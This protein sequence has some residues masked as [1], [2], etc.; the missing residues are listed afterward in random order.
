MSRENPTD[1][2][3]Y[4]VEDGVVTLTLNRPHR[5]NAWLA[6]FGEVYMDRLDQ[7]ALD[8]EV[9]AIVITGAGKHF[10]VGMDMGVLTK[11]VE[12]GGERGSGSEDVPATARR[13]QIHTQSIPKPVIAAVN[14]ACAGMGLIM[15]VMCDLRFAASDARFCSAFSKRG[16]VAEHGISWMLPRL[17]GPSHALDILLSSRIVPAEEAL[18]MGLVNRVTPPE[19]VVAEAQSYARE[20]ARLVAPSSMQTIK[21]QVYEHLNTSPQVAMAESLALMERSLTQSDFKEGVS[22]FVQQRD[23]LFLP[24]PCAEPNT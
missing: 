9:R 1:A 4:E 3:T 8:P 7:A 6:W 18:H 22:S 14:G 16:L 20:L 23:P 13:P 24:V 17:V 12:G 10:C 2:V 11:E 5:G 19:E 21:R 15:A